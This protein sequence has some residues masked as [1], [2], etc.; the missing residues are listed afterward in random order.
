MNNRGNNKLVKMLSLTEEINS[1]NTKV[2]QLIEDLHGTTGVLLN[3]QELTDKLSGKVNEIKKDVGAYE[4]SDN[5]EDAING[6]PSYISEGLPPHRVVPTPDNIHK[7][8]P[9]PT[10]AA[11]K[12]YKDKHDKKWNTRNDWWGN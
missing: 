3:L 10:P 2:R 7:L 6:T 8:N 12:D 11:I 1:I 9:E 5:E 4:P